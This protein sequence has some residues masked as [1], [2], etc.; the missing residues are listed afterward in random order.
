ML[1]RE[2]W[3]IVIEREGLS[4][5]FLAVDSFMYDNKTI[6][7]LESDYYAV[8]FRIFP[9]AYCG[10]STE[11]I[12]GTF[13]NC[14]L[15]ADTV[16][17]FTTFSSR[18]MEDHKYAYNQALGDL[19]N[20][21]V[22]NS[23]ML[24][25][26]HNANIK[27][28]ETHNETTVFEKN[29]LAY[30]LRDYI[31]LV[32]LML[33][34][35]NEQGEKLGIDVLMSQVHKAEGALRKF[36]PQDFSEDSYLQMMS[37]IIRPYAPDYNAR[38]DPSTPLKEQI[39]YSDTMLEDIGNGMLKFSTSKTGE[40]E[41]QERPTEPK[42]SMLKRM[43][44]Q[45]RNIFSKMVEEEDEQGEEEPAKEG[46]YFTKV[47]S[48]KI[49]PRQI[50]LHTISD[51]MMDYFGN[52]VEQQIPVPFLLNLTVKL[53]DAEKAAKNVTENAQWNMWQL[54]HS[55]SLA[56]FFPE[57][58]A[59]AQ[60]AE[61]VVKSIQEDGEIPMKAMWSMLLF[62]KEKSNLDRVSSFVM[63]EFRRRGFILQEE[64]LISIP[65]FL[66]SLPL[67]YH[68]VFRKWSRRF[69][70]IFKSNAAS[71]API[72]TDSR[73]FGEYPVMQ[74]FG[75]NGQ[76]QNFDF[77][78]ST[79][80]N[81]NA[82]L[83]APSGTGK[84]FG[85]SRLAWSYLRNGAKVRIVDSGHSYRGLC[86][87]IGGQ[88]ITFPEGNDHCLNPFTNAMTDDNGHISE[89]ELSSMVISIGI[90]AGLDLTSGSDSNED[91][92]YV[93]A[94]SSYIQEAVLMAWDMAGFEAGLAE[95]GQALNLI[96][97]NQ[98]DEA[99]KQLKTFE[100]DVDARLG[101]L[102]GM[103][104]PF[105]DKK[106]LYYRYVNGPSNVNFVN[107]FVVLDLEDLTSKEKRFRDFV[108]TEITNTVR[109][110]LFHERAENRRKLFI[111]DEAWQLLDGKAGA[112]VAGLYRISRK[113][114]LS[115]L[116]ITQSI[117]DYYKNKH[118]QSI[119]ENAYW[120]LFLQQD[121]STIA[122]A[123]QEGKLMIDDYAFQLLQTV[124]S[125]AGQ[126]SELM[127]MTQS[128][129]LMIGRIL[130][131][132][133]EYWLNTQGEGEVAKVK[134]V[135]ASYGIDEQLARMAIGY[136]EMNKRS[137]TEELQRLSGAEDIAIEELL[138]EEVS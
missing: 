96:S 92:E 45:A 64:D 50:D 106:G 90:M 120:R 44:K 124:E 76:P 93:T 11:E 99:L 134:Q 18:N 102:I 137:V 111:I 35:R 117:N 31:N 30:Y 118:I 126:Y 107:D 122:T 55:G 138:Q 29:K 28:L 79:A 38:R 21:N 23:T 4:E 20:L 68:E 49:F 85:V 17:Q 10:P 34:M 123:K 103:L 15:P 98:R 33:P 43:K 105:I 78:A 82:I 100:S 36:S 16:V 95:V 1:N 54:E 41:G 9:P 104:Y 91:S 80:T 66:Y 67:Q 24:G 127:V 13:L 60:E 26:L 2:E 108:L 53:E 73:G 86:K 14:G 115:I 56:K 88:Y 39:C 83:P 58:T 59:R 87:E 97:E 27:F 94:I 72:V 61:S 37:E 84:S 25:E 132:R 121:P 129:S 19:E 62:G 81:P 8:M 48:K 75:R 128:G 51:L 131:T 46:V 3:R 65:V 114:R 57:L 119:F 70:T 12:L 110:E 74:L 32:T 112:M 47:L 40:F 42:Q 135:S 71:I 130:A 133:V 113:G 22:G 6:Y 109:R 125:I 116:T 63:G 69:S 89:E 77:F 5:F 52:N 136:S 101:R 7:E